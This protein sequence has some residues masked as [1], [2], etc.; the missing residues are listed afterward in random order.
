[1]PKMNGFE[2]Y[3]AEKQIYPGIHMCLMTVYEAIPTNDPV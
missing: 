1:M 2:F 3:H